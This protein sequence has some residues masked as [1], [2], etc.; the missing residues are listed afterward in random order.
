MTSPR[1]FELLDLERD[2]PTTAEDIAALARLRPPAEPDLLVH[3][4][5]LQPPPWLP[6]ARNSRRTSAGWEPFEL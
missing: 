2:I 3:I 5:R 6:P 1:P 4:E